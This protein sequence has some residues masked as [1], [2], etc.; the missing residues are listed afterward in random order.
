MA[1][2]VGNCPRCRIDR[3]TFDVNALNLIGI[4]YGWQHH[5]EAFSV[6]RNCQKSTVFVIVEQHK[7]HDIH[8]FDRESPLDVRNSLNNYFN[9]SGYINLKDHGVN[10]PPEYVPDDVALIFR[11]GATCLNTECWNAAGVMFRTCLDIATRPLLPSEEVAGLNTKMRRDLGLRLQWLFE[12]GVLPSDLQD[13][14]ACVREDG[15]DGAHQGNLSRQDVE[16]IMD[17]SVAL[18]ERLFTE[19]RRIELAKTRR[20]ERRAGRAD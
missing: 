1:D 3:I 2:L 18:L 20:E 10:N 12:T 4:T 15:N 8:L 5:Y 13:L 19:P 7:G 16:D 9:I 17:F 14:A 6:C 11:E